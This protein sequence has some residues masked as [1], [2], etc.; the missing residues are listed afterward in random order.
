[1]V[2]PLLLLG[3]LGGLCG[4][5]RADA[6]LTMGSV[7]ADGLT[8]RDLTCVLS[9][10]GLLGGAI[11]VGAVAKQKAALDACAPAGAS[12]RVRLD[13]HGKT[14]AAVEMIGTPAQR[15]CIQRA[16]GRV[17]PVVT[18]TCEATLVVGKG[19]SWESPPPAPEETPAAAPGEPAPAGGV[20]PLGRLR[21]LLGQRA[22]AR[23]VVAL[24]YSIDQ[25]R[26][27]SSW[28]DSNYLIYKKLGFDLMVRAGKVKTLFLF[29]DGADGHAAYRGE[30]PAGLTWR[31]TRA[32][33]EARLGAPVKSGGDGVI[34]FWAE[35]AGE[36]SVTYVSEDVSRR[37]N[38]IHHIVMVHPDR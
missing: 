7:T 9:S 27:V 14:S 38:P 2:R 19:A 11:V 30:L 5:A 22:D 25:H 18:G 23:P 12:A 10:G 28:P 1:M 8:L 37:D 20:V 32:D 33:V 24:L 4:G 17:R 15:V 29:A 35:Y 6:K 36:V 21:A 13:F 16:L 31:S 26:T 34:P 3:L